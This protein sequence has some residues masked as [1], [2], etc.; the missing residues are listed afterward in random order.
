M[1]KIREKDT[2]GT[3][4]YFGLGLIAAKGI[5]AHMARDCCNTG[6]ITSPYEL[7]ND[8]P[9]PVFGCRFTGDYVNVNQS[10]D[11]LAARNCFRRS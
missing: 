6:K 4:K 5:L 10:Q 7:M 8:L 3:A 2:L 9:G 11:L 1:S